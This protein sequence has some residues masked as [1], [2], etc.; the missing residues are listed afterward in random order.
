MFEGIWQGSEWCLFQDIPSLEQLPVLL[1]Q[2][3][4]IPRTEE[5][6]LIEEEK[7]KKK[8]KK[9]KRRG[10]RRRNMKKDEETKGKQ[11]GEGEEKET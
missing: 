7:K 10:R 11:E 9:N 5:R 3:E 4:G 6:P 1:Q 8:M 2:N